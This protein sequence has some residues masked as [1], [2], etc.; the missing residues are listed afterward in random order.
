M[1]SVI[2]PLYNSSKF[3]CDFSQH[4]LSL[5]IFDQFEWII[6]D[7]GSV[8]ES[9]DEAVKIFSQYTNVIVIKN[10]VNIGGLRSRQKA[11]CHAKYQWIIHLDVD[12]RL[13]EGPYVQF[14][15]DRDLHKLDLITFNFCKGNTIIRSE[16]VYSFYPSSRQFE[17]QLYLGMTGGRIMKKDK[18]LRM[19]LP[20]YPGTADDAIF[21]LNYLNDAEQ[22]QFIDEIA[23]FNYVHDASYTRRVY[24]D[25]RKYVEGIV[26]LLSYLEDFTPNSLY[27][28]ELLDIQKNRV[29]MNALYRCLKLSPGS[30]EY[31]LLITQL[32]DGMSLGN[33]SFF[34]LV[35]MQLKLLRLTGIKGM[36]I[37]LSKCIAWKH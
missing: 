23:Y 2:T 7:D 33:R 34:Q 22:I 11:T 16:G 37:L 20:D 18:V 28:K 31:E 6:I 35:C 5:S 25:D 32:F 27:S 24:R 36:R 3:L 30:S 13:F 21:L 29:R 17:P 8:D 1:I 9:Y 14:L 4:I 26:K 12:D 15:H 10:S 19:S